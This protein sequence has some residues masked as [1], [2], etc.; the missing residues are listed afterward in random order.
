MEKPSIIWLI[1][2]FLLLSMSIVFAGVA[3]NKG[4]EV[5]AQKASVTAKAKANV[6]AAFNRI[7]P[8][9]IVG[10]ADCIYAIYYPTDSD[11]E[12]D[13]NGVLMGPIIS[14]NSPDGFVID[15]VLVV[16]GEV[17]FG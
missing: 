1:A 8:K 15:G 17:T 7:A 16:C 4:S 12:N 6:N 5:S 9:H 3:P 10:I 2:V 14:P 11:Y 13:V